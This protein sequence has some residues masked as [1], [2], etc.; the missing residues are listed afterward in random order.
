[1]ILA[2]YTQLRGTRLGAKLGQYVTSYSIFVRQKLKHKVE[3]E[4]L[5]MLYGIECKKRK[6][7]RISWTNWTLHIVTC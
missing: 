6:R 5:A 1:M 7:K 2:R 3:K 4:H